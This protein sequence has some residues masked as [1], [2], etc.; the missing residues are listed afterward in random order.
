MLPIILGVC[1]ALVAYQAIRRPI[2]RRLA[3]RDAVR[4]PGET[5]LVI[6]GSLLGTA[7]ITGSF[8]VGDTLD[9]SIKQTAYAQLGPVDEIV[10]VPDQATADGIVDQ[11]DEAQDPRVD[12]LLSIVVAQSAI[13]SEASGKKEAEPGAQMI[14]M[15]FGAAR[16]FGN[17]PDTTGIQ[18]DTP[19]PGR[20]VITE[21]LATS[22]GAQQGDPVT[23]FLYGEELD[24]RVDRVL[25]T[26]GL[27][28]YWSG[29]ESTSPNAFVAPGT[30]DGLTP[31]ALPPGVVAPATTVLVSNRGGIEDGALLSD[32]VT[33]LIESAIP[34]GSALR[35]ERTKQETLDAAKEQ[36]DA[37]AE[38]FV[39]I[40]SFAIIAGVLLLVNIFVMLA[41]ERKSQL[42]M[43]RAVGMRRGF[44]VRAFV[45][46]GAIYSILSSVLGALLGI[47]V[48]WAIVKL[49]API[50][51]AFGDFALDLRFDFESSSIVTGFCA[52]ALIS[53][54]TVLITSFRISRINIIRAIRDLPEP[55]SYRARTI[56]VIVGA[57]F[58]ALMV[59][60]FVSSLSVEGAWPLTIL[61][62]PLALLGFLPLSSRLISRRTAVLLAASLSLVW[63]IF[64]SS[65]LGDSFFGNG[66]IFAFV[67]Q[68]V[69]LTFSAVMLLTQGQETLE[70]AIRRVAARRLPLRLSV[71]Y[72]LARRFRTGLTLGMFALVVFTMTFIATL[73]N[74]FGGQVATT[75]AKEGDFE[76]L[77]T[78]NITNPPAVEDLAQQDGVESV[79]GL[80]YG[81]A[82]FQP[83]GFPEPEPWPMSGVDRSFVD[84]G[85]PHL[86]EL[87]PG[88]SKDSEAWNAVIED[89]SKMIVPAFFLQQGGGPAAAI[90]EPGDELSVIDPV[91]GEAVTRTVVGLIENDFAFSGSYV[92]KSSMREIVGERAAASRFY[93]QTSSDREESDDVAD[94][95]EASFVPNGVEAQSFQ[96]LVEEFQAA[97]LQFFQ[98]MQGYLA[99]GLLVGIAGLG[100]VMVRAVRER[101]RDVG[102]LRS[103]G[104]LVKQVRRAFV[105]E[106]GFVALEGIVVGAVLAIVTSSQL[107]AS[108]EFGENIVFEIP[109]LDIGV[110][111]VAALA[112]SLVA[113]AWPAH[114]AS[115]IP[116][117]AALRIA[118]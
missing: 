17:D 39:G 46:E 81:G 42:G 113:T 58:G 93:V 54:F 63:G 80:L 16:D 59:V 9:S 19:G 44:L 83:E 100:V 51:G 60:G 104:F 38:I 24:L 61:G 1:V 43:L 18:G 77:M 53:L 107:V 67:L 78:S 49:A 10:T 5:A 20:V 112:G 94:R 48:G 36:G 40:G 45:I 7:L 92:S 88:M 28:G 4:R 75:A 34:P 99:L 79:S 91:S 85:P 102:V 23:A 70:G 25:P 86:T 37:F 57:I 90:V 87:A 108:G 64:G 55:V 110:L 29:F 50:F 74:V 21:D 22:T 65:I 97:N 26:V 41:E 72:P 3:V 115:Q 6:L 68:G 109:W 30:L 32:E 35:V 89:P 2:L 62:P 114:Q 56:T 52:G 27:A 106:S 117:A 47:G 14:E 82:L 105:L 69:L 15:D 96:A 103:L 31:K 76:I 98:L 84:G 111:T 101:R 66:E 13:V 95:L 11:M 116:P 118:D 73:S 33:E 8:I 71:A 12:G